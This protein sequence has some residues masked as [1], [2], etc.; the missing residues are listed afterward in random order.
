M[1]GIFQAFTG[2]HRYHGSKRVTTTAGHLQLVSTCEIPH[3]DRSNPN[4]MNLVDKNSQPT[5]AAAAA[6]AVDWSKG[7]HRAHSDI[8]DIFTK[9]FEAPVLIVDMDSTDLNEKL[10]REFS[11]SEDLLQEKTVSVGDSRKQ[12][13]SVHPLQKEYQK[14]LSPISPRE[15]SAS[16]LIRVNSKDLQKLPSSDIRNIV[17]AS[18]HRERRTNRDSSLAAKEK[19]PQAS[20]HLGTYGSAKSKSLQRSSSVNGGDHDGFWMSVDGTEETLHSSHVDLPRSSSV[21]AKQGSQMLGNRTFKQCS[22]PMDGKYVMRLMV[23]LKEDPRLLSVPEDD[24]QLSK[25]ERLDTPRW[26][27][28]GLNTQQYHPESKSLKTTTFDFR[29][30]LQAAAEVK[31]LLQ[32]SQQQL[33]DG[34]KFSLEGGGTTKHH[35]SCTITSTESPRRLAV[36]DQ[37][38]SPHGGVCGMTTPPP[39]LKLNTG[40]NPMQHASRLVSGDGA[41]AAAAASSQL[42]NEN[43]TERASYGQGE[44]YRRIPNVVARLMGLE[45]VPDGSADDPLSHTHPAK[46]PKET[47][48]PSS[49]ET[50][51]TQ[52]LLQYTPPPLTVSLPPPPS[53]RQLD[54]YNY[55]QQV[56]EG[57]QQLRQC[58]P[59]QVQSLDVQLSLKSSSSPASDEKEMLNQVLD[60]GE[61]EVPF[62]YQAEESFWT[63][64]EDKSGHHTE[65]KSN[66]NKKKQLE[67][68]QEPPI[69]SLGDDQEMQ[70][71]LQIKSSAQGRKL[72]R[73]ILQAMQLKGPL[74]RPA[75]RKKSQDTKTARL[76]A[77]KPIVD[78]GSKSQIKQASKPQAKE[79]QD[80]PM[81]KT[82]SLHEDD[83]AVI[84]GIQQR[85][86]RSFEQ[87]D[88]DDDESII[89]LGNIPETLIIIPKPIM[90]DA[91]PITDTVMM[92]SSSPPAQPGEDLGSVSNRSGISGRSAATSSMQT[93]VEREYWY[94]NKSRNKVAPKK[95]NGEA[96]RNGKSSQ[97]Q[98]QTSLGFLCEPNSGSSSFSGIETRT[99]T[100]TTTTTTST[101]R[102]RKE[103]IAAAARLVQGRS[104]DDDASQGGGQDVSPMRSRSLLP[105]AQGKHS[106]RMSFPTKEANPSKLG[107]LKEYRCVTSGSQGV[108][109][110][111]VENGNKARSKLP[112]LMVKDKTREETTQTTTRLRF[113][114]QG[115]TKQD[116]LKGIR[117]T[118]GGG[119]DGG[120]DKVPQLLH[121]NSSDSKLI[122]RIAKKLTA[123]ESA[124]AMSNK[125]ECRNNPSEGVILRSTKQPT[126]K[127]GSNNP[128]TKPRRLHAHVDI[129]T[130]H[131]ATTSTK[132]EIKFQ[133][134]T[135][136]GSV[137]TTAADKKHT[138]HREEKNN[139]LQKLMIES[140]IQE[141]G[142]M[143]SRLNLPT[144]LTALPEN[145]V[146]AENISG[147]KSSRVNVRG[148]EELESN[149]M[150]KPGVRITE[151]E[152]VEHSEDTTDSSHTSTSSQI[153]SSNSQKLLQSEEQ[154]DTEL[155][156]REIAELLTPRGVSVKEDKSNAFG[157]AEVIDQPSP[158]SVLDN[159]QFPEEESLPSPRT[160]KTSSSTIDSCEQDSF[161]P[162]HTQHL[163]ELTAALKGLAD[164]IGCNRD[165]NN[166]H[167]P[168]LNKQSVELQVPIDTALWSNPKNSCVHG[169]CLRNKDE[170]K[171]YVRDV[172]V[173]SGVVTEDDTRSINCLWQTHDGHVMDPSHF[174]VLESRHRH[175]QPMFNTKEN[176]DFPF[177][178]CP[179]TYSRIEALGRQVL[180]DGMNEILVKKL[181]PVK[182]SPLPWIGHDQHQLQ[183]KPAGQQLIQEVW[184]ELQGVP[185]VASQNVHDT[186]YT[187]LHKDVRNT[188][189]QWSSMDG[190]LSEVTLEVECTIVKGLID[191]IVEDLIS[192][193]C[194]SSCNL[195]TQT[196]DTATT[197]QQLFAY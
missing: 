1:T 51:S 15:C 107:P 113:R 191:E 169:I 63:H 195:S 138:D 156:E 60:Y 43:A 44:S 158:V 172:L 174:D 171:E 95:E 117:R 81:I 103:R 133:N 145:L 52:G 119:G 183:E 35:P 105:F 143:E 178:R 157:P 116:L 150:Q 164:I 134:A 39:R 3:Q 187:I 184:D 186:L 59:A 66:D 90:D 176:D 78:S 57:F 47:N 50:R 161:D 25:D 40:R 160:S 126:G 142:T 102:S 130:Q 94:T 146:V 37:D 162:P 7:H 6:A 64:P 165:F 46:L 82:K 73:H 108:G 194:S 76:Q 127:P 31:H 168:H 42:K 77:P 120:P 55:K 53:P 45:E 153:T 70:Q 65:V 58:P 5:T 196:I 34:P 68:S 69:C 173:A 104:L 193:F 149:V 49:R 148:T 190:E 100:T 85:N 170:E 155:D 147:R 188:A 54:D 115:S 136:S 17:Q 154:R 48:H 18:F 97:V 139:D 123:T 163:E 185:C 110:Q 11:D 122:S 189:K 137:T 74:L 181:D 16:E 180:F 92:F 67:S 80:L 179:K 96:T 135:L 84:L 125:A 38:S 26:Q 87:D 79:F 4:W 131:A 167:H 29:E 20:V 83:D 56:S 140:S 151:G 177:E 159:F 88:D 22:I 144:A 41:A 61:E 118:G 8:T 112:R 12:I 86:W 182:F 89:M 13:S 192:G 30:S 14:P 141:N 99:T 175:W 128:A 114:T 132:K 91:D 9:T 106:S 28:P 152:A 129:E 98:A 109:S 101:R 121:R 10:G 24:R 36:D 93:S 27:L 75:S 124:A 32:A 166:N 62:Q 197:T 71:Q 33:Q 2:H 72:L 19:L 111:L 21:D 23:E